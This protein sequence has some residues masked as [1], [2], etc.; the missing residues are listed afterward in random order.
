MYSQ[1]TS[2]KILK[3]Q[4]NA[5]TQSYLLGQHRR[6]VLTTRQAAASG[7]R[8]QDVVWKGALLGLEIASFHVVEVRRT[9]VRRWPRAT[10]EFTWSRVPCYPCSVSTKKPA[11]GQ[12][13]IPNSICFIR[14][15][16][17]PSACVPHS[18]VSVGLTKNI[19]NASSSQKSIRS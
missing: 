6:A 14:G 18:G 11:A 12:E 10:A 8:V 4:G 7:S 19:T 13:F 2:T 15:S 9:S 1:S 3:F 16:S 5:E 17:D